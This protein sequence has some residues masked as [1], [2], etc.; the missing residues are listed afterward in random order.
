MF[1]FAEAEVAIERHRLLHREI[2]N[3]QSACALHRSPFV[4]SSLLQT[5]RTGNLSLQSTPAKEW[6]SVWFD[7]DRTFFTCKSKSLGW[8]K[9]HVMESCGRVE[10][11][12]FGTRWRSVVSYTLRPHYFRGQRHKNPRTKKL[13]GHHSR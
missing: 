9:Q 1:P 13:G 7:F 2:D 11:S 8:M 10:L 3:S 5:G 6:G 4:V 12:S